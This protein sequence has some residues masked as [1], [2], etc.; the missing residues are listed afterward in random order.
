MP[1]DITERVRPA[2]LG[3]D[4]GGIGGSRPEAEAV[5]AGVPEGAERTE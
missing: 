3:A 4:M 1:F 5:D 2:Y